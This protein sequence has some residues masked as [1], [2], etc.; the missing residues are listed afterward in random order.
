MP[1]RMRQAVGASTSISELFGAI[2]SAPVW[3][4]MFPAVIFPPSM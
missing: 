2:G 4:W 3:I 1:A